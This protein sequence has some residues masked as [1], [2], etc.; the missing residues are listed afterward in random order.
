MRKGF[1]RFLAAEGVIDAQ[2]VQGF[3]E[4]LR[5]APEPLGVIAFRYGMITGG[6]IDDILDTQRR[7]DRPFGEIAVERGLL[8][9]EQVRTLLFVQQ[10]RAA[11]ETAEALALAG[12]CETEE[13]MAQL[14]RFLLTLRRTTP[15]AS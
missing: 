12:V 13:V 1:L 9:H 15:S 2:R 5:A 7:D 6:D 14:G 11:T 4:T 10:M 8:T 3:Q